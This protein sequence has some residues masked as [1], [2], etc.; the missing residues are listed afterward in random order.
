MKNRYIF[1]SIVLIILISTF[2]HLEVEH[3]NSNPILIQNEVVI[4]IRELAIANEL[5]KKYTNPKWAILDKVRA[6]VLEIQIEADKS[7][8]VFISEEDTREK[9]E[10]TIKEFVLSKGHDG[11]P[12]LDDYLHYETD[13]NQAVAWSKAL[14]SYRFASTAEEK[15]ELINSLI[16]EVFAREEF[17]QTNDLI[18]C[19]TGRI[20]HNEFNENILHIVFHSAGDEKKSEHVSVQ[21]HREADAASKKILSKKNV[22]GVLY[23]WTTDKWELQS[24]EY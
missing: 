20:L 13:E 3:K 16:Q 19:G 11:L 21:S 8:N 9:Y 10:K 17:D 5:A 7:H 14:A 24:C 22:R 15:L 6:S 4:P 23:A 12:M 18:D 1:I 2:S